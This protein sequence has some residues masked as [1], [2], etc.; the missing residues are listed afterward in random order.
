VNARA[1]KAIDAAFRALAAALGASLAFEAWHDVSKAW[2]TWYYHLPFAARIAGVIDP[3]SYAFSPGNERRFAGFPLLAEAAQGLLWRITG[4]VE[5]A[6]FVSLACIPALAIFLKRLFRVPPHLTVLALLAVPLVQI[7]ATASYV[8]LPANTCAAMLV[9]C[10]YRA[11]VAREPPSMRALACAGALAA[12]AANAKFQ[13]VPLVG[14]AALVIA[15]R[16]LAPGGGRARRLVVLAVFVPIVLATPIKNAIVHANPVYPVALLGLPHAEAPYSSSP[17]WL[18]HAPRP[19]RFACSVLEIGLRPIASHRR[20]SLDQWTPPSEDG[21]R[22]GGFFGA[23]VVANL[24]ALA[25]AIARRRRSPRDR[26]RREGLAAG[27]FVLGTTVVVSVM[28]QSHELRY[29]LVWM[30]VLVAVNLVLWREARLPVAAIATAALVVVAWS[31]GGAFLYASGDSFA[32]LVR[33]KTDARALDAIHP[34]ERVCVE[35]E[36]WTFLYAPEFHPG[37]RYAVQ[38]AERDDDCGALRKLP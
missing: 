31:T 21:Y 20:W 30:L 7:H 25:A 28:P 2:D 1:A 17:G 23:Y 4:R 6:N 16:A 29:Y 19:A 9:L 26:E 13:L 33:E 14:L 37:K 11:C 3:A 8:D 5:C 24:V 38:E 12:A 15:A 18:A 22:M 34:G 36:P 27:A 32:E 10:A 35:R